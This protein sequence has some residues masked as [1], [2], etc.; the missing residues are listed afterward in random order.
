MYPRLPDDTLRDILYKKM[1]VSKVLK[2]DLAHYDRQEQ[3]HLHRKYGW[4]RGRIDYHLL[5]QLQ[6]K[7]QVEKTAMLRGKQGAPSEPL[8]V[9]AKAKPKSKA[10]PAKSAPTKAKPQAAAKATA[11]GGGGGVDPKLYEGVCFFFQEGSCKHGDGCKFEHRKLGSKVFAAMPRPGSVARSTSA[12]NGG[13]GARTRS[14]PGTRTARVPRRRRRLLP[15]AATGSQNFGAQRSS[16][17]SA[18]K[19]TPA[20]SRTFLK[21]A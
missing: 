5:R 14:A 18:T 8:A 10:V 11:K 3:G 20:S 19:A 21:K 16:R 17:A 6:D 4:L 13:K 1:Q 9:P 2:E 7:N 15:R 12:K